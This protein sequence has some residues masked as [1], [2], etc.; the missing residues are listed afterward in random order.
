MEMLVILPSKVFKASSIP[1]VRHFHRSVS[2]AQLC[3]HPCSL[4]SRT[5]CNRRC[6]NNSTRSFSY[7]PMVLSMT[8]LKRSTWSVNLPR[9]P[10]P[11]SSSASATPTFR[12]WRP[13]METVVGLEIQEG[14][15]PCAT[16]CNSWNST[17]AS[18]VA[19]SPSKCSRKCH[20][21]SAPTWRASVSSLSP[22]IRPSER[23]A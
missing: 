3:L 9:C 23:Q 2:V 14:N 15:L 5:T 8:C 6:L 16:L 4:S 18:P 22:L 11:S 21:R 12:R 13:L 7:S 19:T 20:S 10:A 17:R 1:T